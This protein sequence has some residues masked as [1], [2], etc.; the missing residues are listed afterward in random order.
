MK[1]TRWFVYEESDHSRV[2]TLRCVF[3]N[4]TIYRAVFYRPETSPEE[5]R[6]EFNSSEAAKKLN[7]LKE[8]LQPDN[9][10]DGLWWA[11]ENYYPIRPMWTGESVSLKPIESWT[12]INGNTGDVVS[13][14]RQRTLVEGGAVGHLSHL[15]ENRDLTFAE[16]KEI[17]TTAAEGRLEKV[18]EKLDGMNCVFT[19]NAELGEL[20]VARSGGDIKR[21]G[22]DAG[23]LADKF[24]DR[25]NLTDAFNS[26]FKVLSDVI[27]TMPEEERVQVFGDSAN[28]WYSVEII[29]TANPNVVNYDGNAVVFHG[30]PVFE[31]DAEGN[32]SKGENETGVQL[33]TSNVNRMQKAVTLRNWQVR[34]PAMVNLKKLS[35]GSVAQAAIDKISQTQ[36]DAGMSDSNTINDYLTALM[37]EEVA[38][39]GLPEEAAAATVARSLNNPGAPALTA[40]KKL[41][42]KERY[43]A[44]QDFVKGS[45]VLLKR[46]IAPIEAA[47]QA[48]AVTLLTG[49]RSSLVGSHDEEVARLRQAVTS[50]V[51]AIESSGNESAMEVLKRQMQKLGS[52]ENITTPVEGVVFIWKGNAYKF[53]GSFAAANQILGLFKYGRGKSPPLGEAYLREAVEGL[54]KK[55]V[56]Q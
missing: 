6:I 42:P 47:I 45:P 4:T 30:W 17:L 19:W 38:N 22:M 29:Y 34:G 49:L 31:A 9:S 28:F 26:A 39:L 51:K 35:D 11:D 40:I 21:G 25:G 8:A 2:V 12:I 23:Q 46:F 48:F 54:R 7:G 55:C 1:S 3:G 43:P 10:G 33:L 53:T 44:V 13:E 41:V 15:Y 32:V 14:G 24:K 20:K 56:A 18:S 5:V 37:S 36:S 52:V 27:T 16:L 50:A